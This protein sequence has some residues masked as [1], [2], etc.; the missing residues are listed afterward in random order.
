MAKTK[1]IV[2]PFTNEHGTFNP[3][4]E[5]IAITVCTKRVNVERVEYVGYIERN[6]YDWRTKQYEPMHYAQVRRPTTQYTSFWKG[7]DVKAVW[8]YGDREVEYRNVKK[9]IITTLQYNR[10]IPANVSV[11]ELI[12]RI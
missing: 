4:D 6:D 10:I 7:T 8:P 9:Y 11:N 1:R 5:V 3:G 2:A 12:E